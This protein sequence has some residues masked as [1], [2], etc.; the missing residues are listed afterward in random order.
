[1]SYCILTNSVIQSV[2]ETDN[3]A[4]HM[5]LSGICTTTLLFAITI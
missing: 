2:A 5:Y 1:M 4:Y 3:S